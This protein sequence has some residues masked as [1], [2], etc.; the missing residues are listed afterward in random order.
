M[1]QEEEGAEASV[2]TRGRAVGNDSLGN[3][4]VEAFQLGVKSSHQLKHLLLGKE[5]RRECGK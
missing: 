3:L 5:S 4:S 2:S 1:E